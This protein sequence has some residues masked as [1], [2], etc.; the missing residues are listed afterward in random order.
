MKK[1]IT[2][3]AVTALLS[4]TAVFSVQQSSVVQSDIDAFQGHFK[5]R[6][7]ELSLNDFS[8]GPYAMSEDKMSQFEAL[9]EMPPFEDHVEK[10]GKLWKTAFK[11]GKTYSS[12]FS[13]DDETIRT[14]YPRW[15]AAKGKVV[16]LEKALLDCRVKNGEKKIGSGKGKLA[17]ISAYLTTIAEGQTINVIV[18][19]GDEKALAAYNAGKKFFYA[20]RGQLNLSC[21]NCHVDNPGRRI[22]G[23]TLS[24]ALG[25]VTHFPVWRGKWAKKKGDGFGTIQRRYGGCNKQVR[26]QPFKRQKDAYSNLEYFHTI[27]SNGMEISGTEYRE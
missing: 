14:Q 25:Q 13:G 18:P 5:K 27:M 19:E 8:K 23:N 16:S 7:P 10:G 9:M 2:T 24:P 11:N 22:R 6:F 12:C 3:V 20:K 17:W 26:A 4:S 1:I 21:A 15:D